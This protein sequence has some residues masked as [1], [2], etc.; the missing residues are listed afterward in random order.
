MERVCVL[1]STY[2]GEKYL[3]SQLDSI[4]NQKN[5][6][7]D[8]LVRDDGSTDNTLSILQEYK[9]KGLLDWYEGDNLG[10]AKS[11]WDLLLNANDS[12]YYAFADQDD[13]WLEEKLCRAVSQIKAQITDRPILYFS[14]KTIVNENLEEFGVDDEPVRGVGLQF[15][16][17][18][19]FAAGC[20]MVFNKKLY[21]ELI[22]YIPEVMSMH[23][24][25]VLKVAGAVGEITFDSSSYILYRQHSNNTIGN[26][27]KV[28]S[29]KRHLNNIKKYK[30]DDTRIIMSRQ[31]LENYSNQ[32]NTNDIHFTSL[33]ANARC[34]SSARFKLFFSNYFKTQNKFDIVLFKVF[35]LLGWV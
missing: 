30:S 33:L 19:G 34:S 17:L 24:S 22:K 16:L 26:Q 28:K 13:F 4:L 9:N 20:T 7:V 15:S 25:W 3:T 29:F 18:R 31:L 11:F 1:L 14:K 12:E 10:S 21:L 35:F 6:V 5:V 2:N 32:M 27:T 8:L 23:D